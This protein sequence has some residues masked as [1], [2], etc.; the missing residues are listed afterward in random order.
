MCAGPHAVTLARRAPW[1]SR[2]SAVLGGRVGPAILGA[3]LLAVSQWVL[4]EGQTLGDVV[5]SRYGSYSSNPELARRL[6]SPL[7]AARLQRDF[8]QAGKA[9]AAQPLNLADEKFVV[10]VPAQQPTRGYG[11][12]VF[13][14][15]W[16]DARVPAG[17]PAVLDRYGVIFVSAAR[18]GNEESTF[19]RR[20]PLALSAAYNILQQYPVDAEHT[21]VAG[22][23]GGSR[24]ALRLGLGYPDLFRGAI[25]NAG[26]GPIG[27]AEVPLPPAELLLQFQSST[28]LV[29]VTGDRDAD[30]LTDDSWSVRSMHKWCVF[31]T[32]QYV[33]PHVGHEVMG[34][35]A[36]A[37]A[38]K[39][40]F[41]QADPKPGKLAACRSP[42]E[43]ALRDRL[44]E[45]QSL[46]SSGRGTEADKMLS[47]ID[48]EYG[49]LAAPTSLELMSK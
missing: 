23:S 29:Y 38:F 13:V 31:N 43:A 6:V 2:L 8:A 12:L 28:R 14:P 1:P 34:P 17:W 40:L 11:L 32:D 48:R 22:F 42:I 5:F 25:L 9:L 21:Y 27:D 16:E 47:A 18:S 49:G 36:L 10:Y 20:E 33:E 41:N 4:A 46:R 3:V 30:Q 35:A 39:S 26:S 7:N 45:V 19:G 24:V 37:S 44:H 15:P